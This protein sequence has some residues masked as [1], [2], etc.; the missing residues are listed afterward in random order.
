MI[1]QAFVQ[2]RTIIRKKLNEEQF[3]NSRFIRAIVVGAFGIAP[4]L[5]VWYQ[6]L[7][8]GIL[9]LRPF[10]NLRPILKSI[11][12]AAIDQTTFSFWVISNYMFWVSYLEVA[13]PY[14]SSSGIFR[15]QQRM[16]K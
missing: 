16:S 14:Y 6:Y 15:V 4:N 1:G 2:K 11:A 9:G 13:I 7:L 5:I 10:K 12:G 8:P 3:D